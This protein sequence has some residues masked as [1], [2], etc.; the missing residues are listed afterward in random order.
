M[1]LPKIGIGLGP[2]LLKRIEGLVGLCAP[3]LILGLLD[4]LKFGQYGTHLKWVFT[5]LVFQRWRCVGK[6]SDFGSDSRDSGSLIGSP[7][8]DKKVQIF[9]KGLLFGNFEVFKI[10][11][12]IVFIFCISDDYWWRHW[13]CYFS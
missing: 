1:R 8:G 11:E 3:K 6:W 13:M 9:I 7:S 10:T 2:I 4:V 5:S 12:E